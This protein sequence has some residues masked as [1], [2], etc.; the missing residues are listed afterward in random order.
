MRD[1]KLHFWGGGGKIFRLKLLKAVIIF[2]ISTLKFAKLQSLVQNKKVKS[3][4]PKM[5]YLGI[6]WATILKN[7]CHI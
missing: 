7:S 2:E 5:P 1:Q 3:L 6:F 4:G